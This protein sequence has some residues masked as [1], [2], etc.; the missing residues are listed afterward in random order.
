M[1]IHEIAE[2][3][4]IVCFFFYHPIFE[5]IIQLAVYESIQS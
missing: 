1:K 4:I 2:L 5:N 3:F